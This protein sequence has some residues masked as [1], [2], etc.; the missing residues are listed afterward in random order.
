MERTNFE[1]HTRFEFTSVP[2][3]T[4]LLGHTEKQDTPITPDQLFKTNVEESSNDMVDDN[5]ENAADDV[6]EDTMDDV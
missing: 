6:V 4:I 2:P 5:A 1:P 3:S